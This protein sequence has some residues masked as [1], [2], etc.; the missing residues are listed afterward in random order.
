MLPGLYI[1]KMIIWTAGLKVNLSQMVHLFILLQKI[2][3]YM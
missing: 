3:V 1:I 2:R